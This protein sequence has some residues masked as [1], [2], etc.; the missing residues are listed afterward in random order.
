MTRKEAVE[1]AQKIAKDF[2]PSYYVEPFQPHEWVIKALMEAFNKGFDD[3]WDE[4]TS[5]YR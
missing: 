1:L 2:Q 3:G 5:R 4:S